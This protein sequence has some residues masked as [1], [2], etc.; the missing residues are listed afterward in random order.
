MKLNNEEAILKNLHHHW[1]TFVGRALK[2]VFVIPPFYLVAFIF[3]G[4]LG[5]V[6][7][8][9]L[10]FGIAIFFA[11]FM[12]YDLF[13]YYMDKLI[14]TTRRVIHVDWKGVFRMTESE[15]DIEDIQDIVIREHG[16]IAYFSW[17]DY[18]DFLVET[19]STKATINFESAP[20]PKGIKNF[21]YHLEIKP[22]KIDSVQS[23]SPIINDRER[24]TEER[25][26]TYAGINE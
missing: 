23:V 9:W 6:S 21:I 8:A 19:A 16:F 11:L 15:V 4:L 22:T 24:Q 1:M 13:F 7:T 25:A 10:Y 14:I 17:F 2:Y 3:S 5:K 26:A 20:D 12:A 18:G